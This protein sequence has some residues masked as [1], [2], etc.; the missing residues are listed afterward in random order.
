MHVNS[1][2]YVVANLGSK[3]MLQFAVLEQVAILFVLI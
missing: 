2:V 1:N 3:C